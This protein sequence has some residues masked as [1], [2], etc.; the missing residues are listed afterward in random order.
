MIRFRRKKDAKIPTLVNERRGWL[1]NAVP[2]PWRAKSVEVAVFQV[3]DN[4]SWEVL[5]AGNGFQ[6]FRFASGYGCSSPEVAYEE[7]AKYAEKR[8][9]GCAVEQYDIDID[10]WLEERENDPFE[11]L[12]RVRE[13]IA[14][15]DKPP[16]SLL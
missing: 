4:W 1:Y 2:W 6:R 5:E 12:K 10:A 8:S 7:A 9:P 16:T 3:K 14:A 15:L 11:K 13:Q